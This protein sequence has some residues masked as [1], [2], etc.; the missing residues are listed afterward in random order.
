VSRAYR[1][2]LRLTVLTTRD[3]ASALGRHRGRRGTRVLWDLADR[4]S[5][6]P[7]SKTRSNAEA[8]ALEILHDAG[9]ARPKVNVRVAG[10]EADLVW[11]DR[12][13]VIEVDGPQYHRFSDEDTRKQDA[14]ESVG[15]TVKRI[16]SDLVYADP[17][18]LMAL[19]AP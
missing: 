4:Y 19:A 9:I 8:R 2:A 18:A 15:Y 11:P 3:L 6:L 7:Y 14:W 17:D 1:E 16:S 13:L 5:S 10:A 12:R